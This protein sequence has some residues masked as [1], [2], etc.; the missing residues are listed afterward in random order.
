MGGTVIFLT[1]GTQAP[2]DRLVRA[3]D[4]W[5]A[6]HD[7]PVFGQLGA[8]ATDSIRPTNFPWEQFI[9]ADAYQARLQACDL[10]VAHAGMGSII[11]ALTWGKPILIMPRRAALGEHRNEHQLATAEKFRHRA[12]VHVAWEEVEVAPLLDRLLAAAPSQ[13]TAGLAPGA[14]AQL[15]AT[16]RAFITDGARPR[17]APSRV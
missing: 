16:L 12:G 10:L 4:A 15:I 9:H 7:T 3:V 13:T 17:R 1:I 5:A 11:S 2:F 8:L 6:T 14:S